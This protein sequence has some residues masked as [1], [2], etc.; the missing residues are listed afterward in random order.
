MRYFR[1]GVARLILEP[2][3]CP[4]IVPIWLEGNDQVMHE[5]RAPPRWVPRIGK[6]CAVWFGDNVG[7][8]SGAV[9]HEL[10]GRWRRLVNEVERKGASENLEIGELNDE[11]KYGEDAVRLR[12][13]CTIQ[14]R[15]AVLGVR[16]LRGLPDEDPKVGLVETWR[17]EGG[18]R[19]GS[20]ADGSLVRDT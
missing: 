13:E 1:W 9:F 10:R 18:R 11:L 4:D 16:R 3:E 12:E 20:M 14:V 15:K 2:D 8:E 17:E 6:H 5:N 19:E 7:G